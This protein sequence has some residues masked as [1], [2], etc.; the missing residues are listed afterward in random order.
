MKAIQILQ[1]GTVALIEMPAPKPGAEELLLKIEALG[2][3][4]SDLN[5]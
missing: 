5:S 3:C 2:L 4:G 1:P